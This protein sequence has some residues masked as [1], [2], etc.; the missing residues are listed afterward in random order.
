MPRYL[1][2][3]S[4][5]DRRQHDRAEF[6]RIWIANTAKVF[7]DAQRVLLIA[8]AGSQI[9]FPLPVHYQSVS[10]SGDLGHVTDL[11][12]KR[13]TNEFAG[14]TGSMLAL[15]MLA[16]CDE[17][18]FIYKES[19]CLAFGNILGQMYEDLSP[20]GDICFGHAQPTAPGMP[21]SQS[22]FIVRHRF[23]PEFVRT[24]MSLGGDGEVHGEWKFVHLM[25][26]IGRKR[27]RM[28][29]FG[30]DRC[31]PL[32]WERPTWY[33]QQVYSEEVAEMKS[34]NLI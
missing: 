23:L 21:S 6:L 22:L 11:E 19:D 5:F 12:A 3:S 15:A 20:D 24:Y 32:P 18:D 28:L 2:G 9:P 7:P 31:R 29:S 26:K 10:L 25:D 30:V 33:C 17:C 34:R 13:K 27:A 16:Y 8:E 4:Y 14:W 1:I